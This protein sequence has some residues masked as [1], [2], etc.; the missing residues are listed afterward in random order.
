MSARA[1]RRTVISVCSTRE[2]A[3]LSARD[4]SIRSPRGEHAGLG[5]ST[6]AARTTTREEHVPFAPTI[7]AAPETHER[8]YQGRRNARIAHEEI[9]IRRARDPDKG[10]YPVRHSRLVVSRLR[11]ENDARDG[12]PATMQRPRASRAQNGSGGRGGG[13]YSPLGP[14]P[15]SYRRRPNLDCPE[16][17]CRG[18]RPWRGSDGLGCG[19]EGVEGLAGSM[20]GRT[21]SAQAAN[22]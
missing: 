8:T 11:A 14:P 18:D 20:D 16:D 1:R 19:D 22:S 4:R 7:W 15:G 9:A 6:A 13:M 10:R 17:G 21:S 5:Q 3:K 2:C 12:G